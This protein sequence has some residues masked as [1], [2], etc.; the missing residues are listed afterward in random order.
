MRKVHEVYSAL[1]VEQ[2]TDYEEVKREILK[3][4]KL[5]PETYCQQFCEMKCK[6]GQIYMEFVHQKEVL[7]N[8]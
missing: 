3:A 2:S 7:F 5:V 1:S 8:R 6:E 4:Y